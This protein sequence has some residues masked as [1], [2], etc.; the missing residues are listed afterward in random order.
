MKKFKIAIEETVVD[1]FEIFADSAEEAIEA[2][3]KQYKNGNVVLCPGEVQYKQIA[4]KEPENEV[5]EFVEF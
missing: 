3:K 4:I 2:V 1:E 5:T